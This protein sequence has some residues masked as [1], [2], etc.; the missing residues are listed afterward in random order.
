MGEKTVETEASADGN[1]ENLP[2]NDNTDETSAEAAM[3][4]MDK[5][6]DGFLSLEEVMPDEIEIPQNEKDLVK[7]SFE[8]GDADK[9]GKLSAS[10]LPVAMNIFEKMSADGAKQEESEP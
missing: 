4:A 6:K 3:K 7:K 5:D 2:E 10:E 1:G 8:G 9:D